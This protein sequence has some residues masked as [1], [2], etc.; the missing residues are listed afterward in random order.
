MDTLPGTAGALR[1]EVGR[2]RQRESRRVFDV[3]VYLGTLGGDRDCFVVRRQDVPAMDAAL[4]REVVFALLVNA[5]ESMTSMWLTRPGPPEPFE[6][7]LAWLLAAEA[8]FAMHE[9]VLASFHVITR[10]G[11]RDVRTGQQRTWKRLRLPSASATAA[12][13]DA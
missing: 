3:H 7:D 1:L 11:W 2:L 5:P 9:R 13:P 10:Y 8:A 12:A 6:S 4:R